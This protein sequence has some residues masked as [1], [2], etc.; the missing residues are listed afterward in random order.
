MQNFIRQHDGQDEIEREV[1]RSQRKQNE[2]GNGENHDEE[3]ASQDHDGFYAEK[4][5]AKRFRDQIATEMWIDY[6]EL[7]KCRNQL[8]EE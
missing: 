7:L 5:A 1:L 3:E 8:I 6:Q 2:E 4:E